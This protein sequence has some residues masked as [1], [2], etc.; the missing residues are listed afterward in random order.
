[1]QMETPDRTR[2]PRVRPAPELRI[3]EPLVESLSGGAPLYVIPGGQQEVCRVELLF[4]AGTREDPNR[5][6]APAVSALLLNGTAQRTA[7]Q[8]AERIEF[9]GASADCDSSAEYAAV[10]VVC[11][12]KFLGEVVPVIAEAI[13][14]ASI[15]EREL[16][17]Y[18]T[19]SMQRQRVQN[20][21]VGYV[22]RKLLH[23]ALFGNDSPYGHYQSEEEYAALDR[24]MLAGF[25][26]GNC[27][28]LAGII[29]SGKVADSEIELISR[30]LDGFGSVSTESVAAGN[31]H[32]PQPEK[33]RREW[34]DA[35]QTSLRLGL[36]LFDRRHPDFI[37]M[38]VLNCILGG[39]FGSRLMSNIREDKGYS[40]GIGSAVV[41]LSGT[42]FMYISTEVNKQSRED[43]LNEIYAE[44]QEL[45]DTRV[46]HEELDLV[47]NYMAGMLQR[48]FDGPFAA[49]SAFRNVMLSG[50]DLSYY[51]D[52][53]RGLMDA[54]P[55]KLQELAGQ[56]LQKESFWEVSVG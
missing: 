13:L 51:R 33:I 37:P 2:E 21:K 43:A 16:E 55:G 7:E 39:Y 45:T 44:I 5:L 11:L 47:R 54:T 3:Q 32:R 53:M 14:G 34:P 31:G 28:N 12:N 20:K 8:I 19:Q 30:H 23:R 10:S 49:A 22:S 48:G 29:V 38:K 40:Y 1:M 26:K 17:L 4:R 52:F 46:G 6:L 42:G 56:Y 25:H 24:R 9:F 41:P 18:I 36:P 27:R 50:M 15:P 35:M